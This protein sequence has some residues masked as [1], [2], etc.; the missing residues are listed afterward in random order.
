M[1]N[2][3]S[4]KKIWPLLILVLLAIIGLWIRLKGFDKYG[5]NTADEYYIIKSVKNI[6]DSGLPEFASGGYYARGILYQ[7]LSAGLIL[8]GINDVTAL[9]IIPV[10]CN[11]LSIPVVYLIAKKVTNKSFALFAVFLF[12]F[13]VWEI[14]ISRLARFYAPF[15]LIFLWYIYLLLEVIVDKKFDNYKWLYLLSVIGLLVHEEGIFLVILNFLPHY[16]HKNKSKILFTTIVFML[17]VFLTLFS[18][19][20]SGVVNHLP[21]DVVFDKGSYFPVYIPKLLILQITSNAAWLVSFLIPF[22]AFIIYS[23]YFIKKENTELEVKFYFFLVGLAALLNLFSVVIF[24]MLIL[25][26][27]K[28]INSTILQTSDIVRI[29]VFLCISFIFYAVY[30]VT[31][32]GWVKWFNEESFSLSKLILLLFNYPD[33]YEK[34]FIAWLKPFPFLTLIILISFLAIIILFLKKS[35]T[36]KPVDLNEDIPNL[37]LIVLI[38][39]FLITVIVTPFKNLR[40]WFFIYPLFLVFIAF[41]IFRAKLFIKSKAVQNITAYGFLILIFFISEDHNLSH[42]INIDSKEVSFRMNYPRYLAG[43]YYYK[44]DYESGAKIIKE[45]MSNTDLIVT[46]VAPIE[47]YLPKLDYYYRSYKDPE[48]SV[49]SRNK[50]TLEVWTNTKLIYKENQLI[51]LIEESKTNIWL[52]TYSENRPGVPEFDKELIKKY[53]G[54]PSYSNLDGSLNIY[55]I[56]A[57]HN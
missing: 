56:K 19:R 29:A 4:L 34:F 51:E 31:N 55:Y 26:F 12:T 35:F 2:K 22:I 46:T 53:S 50:G 57:S 7:Y 21:A 43:T 54:N 44:E 9:R 25:I 27:S 52:I 17:G 42:L 13:S 47:Y 38:L 39:F 5:F 20:N 14:E 41:I 45:K 30:C 23:R 32:P 6:L 48:F 15:Q 18:F 8:L 10:I 11:I 33:I 36:K 37:M 24:L 28:R 1:S 40:Y 3:L 49:R 16:I